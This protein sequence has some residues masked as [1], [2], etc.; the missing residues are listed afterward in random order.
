[1]RYEYSG[2]LG[3]MDRLWVRII[4]KETLAMQEF[5]YE[6]SYEIKYLAKVCNI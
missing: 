5:L 6:N 1:M 2:K 3:F 4:T